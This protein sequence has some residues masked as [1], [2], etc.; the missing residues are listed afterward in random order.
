MQPYRKNKTEALTRL[1]R[2]GHGSQKN[3]HRFREVGNTI[4]KALVFLA[5]LCEMR[6]FHPWLKA[7]ADLTIR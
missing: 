5:T 4:R 3:E 1:L 2:S 6:P 7:L